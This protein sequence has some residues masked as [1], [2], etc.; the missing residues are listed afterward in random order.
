MKRSHWSTTF[1][2]TGDARFPYEAVVDGELWRV[3]L[4]AFPEEPSLYS[5]LVGGE[6]VEELVA[7]PLAWA[8]PE[9]LATSDDP[10]ERA[11][12]ER[13]LAHVE[14]TRPIPPSK[15]VK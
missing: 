3:R 6:V 1:H 12:Y 5:L 2:S 9:D 13:E 14:H 8:R 7:W 11:E 4:N 10:A 15:L